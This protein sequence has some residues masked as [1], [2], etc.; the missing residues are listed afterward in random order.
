MKIAQSIF[1]SIIHTALLA[2]LVTISLFAPGCI[3]IE[4]ANEAAKSPEAPAI[5]VP[6]E[7]A[8]IPDDKPPV[9]G[10][11]VKFETTK[12]D[13]IVEVNED[14]APLG[15]KRFF[16]LVK[17]GFYDQCRFFRV[18][19]GFMVQFGIN[20]DPAINTK[21][22]AQIPDDPVKTSNKKGT[23]TFATS[24]QDSRTTQ[25]FIN[26]ADNTFLDGQGF[27]PFGKVISGMDV[28]ESILSKHGESPDQGAIQNVGNAYL[29]DK[30]PDL[31]L[32]IKAK[33]Y[34]EEARKNEAEKAGATPPQ[35]NSETKPEM[36]PEPKTEEPKTETKADP[37][38]KADE[39]KP[40]VETSKEPTNKE[41]MKKEEPKP[42]ESK[43]AEANPAETKPEPAK[44]EPAK[45]EDKPATEAT[46]SSSEKPAEKPQ[47]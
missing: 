37:A 45:P 17:S 15:A 8:K 19:P 32:I 30:F 12:G 2:M 5:E 43:P 22:K 14:L 34:D 31:D 35:T 11:Q 20:G 10:Y 46:S 42:A 36:K 27:S 3:K 25:V 40:A 6:P 39:N 9:N 23:I 44:S 47:E 29:I 33:I 24:G 16:N 28:V 18:L 26:Y 13:F 7:E 21:W 4:N 1:P 38:A 41:Y